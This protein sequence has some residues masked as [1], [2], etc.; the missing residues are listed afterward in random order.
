MYSSQCSPLIYVTTVP[1]ACSRKKRWG[2][3]LSQEK[4]NLGG[5]LLFIREVWNVLQL[6]AAGV[7]AS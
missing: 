2:L 4:Q 5:V 6:V 7:V 1:N 3:L